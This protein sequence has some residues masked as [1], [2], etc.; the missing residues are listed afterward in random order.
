MTS[1]F[2]DQVLRTTLYVY[3]EN[4]YQPLPT[5]E[6]VLVCHHST[7]AEEVQL[8][9]IITLAI[10]ILLLKIELFWM[11]AIS[12]KRHRRIFCLIHAEKLTYQVSDLALR[13]LSKHSQG[14]KGMTCDG[15][16]IKYLVIILL[17]PLLL[18]Y[19]IVI[20]CSN[21][22]EE[23]SFLISKLH[24]YKRQFVPQTDIQEFKNYLTIHFTKQ[25]NKSMTLRHEAETLASVV[26]QEKYVFKVFMLMTVITYLHCVLLSCK[27][28]L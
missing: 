6:E 8:L 28:L 11:K 7:T 20:I 21:E 27:L 4:Y 3:M 2:K 13:S 9:I 12:D 16:L 1:Y 26:D 23:K 17:L 22:D 19:R 15:L 24:L 18:E 14:K 5:L 10:I 25:S